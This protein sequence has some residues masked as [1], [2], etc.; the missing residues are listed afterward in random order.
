MSGQN[1]P[2]WWRMPLNLSSRQRVLQTFWYPILPSLRVV[3]PMGD[4]LTFSCR[5]QTWPWCVRTEDLPSCSAGC[6]KKKLPIENIARLANG[7]LL[8]KLPGKSSFNVSFVF[9]VCPVRPLC[10]V[11]DHHDYHDYHDHGD[12]DGDRRPWG[13]WK[14]YKSNLEVIWGSWRMYTRKLEVVM[15]REWMKRL[16]GKLPR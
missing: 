14:L 12:Q 9:P 15:N 8:Q 5:P 11:H 10:P 16:C 2:I 13:S 1:L 7:A 6:P 4:I 3:S